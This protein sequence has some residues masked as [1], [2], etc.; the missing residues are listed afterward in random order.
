MINRKWLKYEHYELTYRRV[1]IGVSKIFFYFPFGTKHAAVSCKLRNTEF[2]NKLICHD[3]NHKRFFIRHLIPNL[4]Y[5][6]NTRILFVGIYIFSLTQYFVLKLLKY[7][8][9]LPW[10]WRRNLNKNLTPTRNFGKYLTWSIYTPYINIRKLH[11]WWNSVNF[12]QFSN[13][14]YIL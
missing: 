5:S 14:F 2:L 9:H 7:M 4:N 3:N 11:F 1:L 6:V 10:K 8:R 12:A 13:N